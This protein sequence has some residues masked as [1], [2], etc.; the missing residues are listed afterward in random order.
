MNMTEQIISDLQARNSGLETSLNVQTAKLKLYVERDKSWAMKFVHLTD[1]KLG[2]EYALA[3]LKVKCEE[4]EKAL[5]PKK[6]FPIH[7][8]S[9][10]PSV[11]WVTYSNFLQSVNQLNQRVHALQDELEEKNVGRQ[12]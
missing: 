4:Y 12:D 11:R 6:S 8:P 3:Q 7:E 5:A 9:E 1:D 2:L 10:Q